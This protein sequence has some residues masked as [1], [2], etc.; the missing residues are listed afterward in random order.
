MAFVPGYDF[1]IFI[2]RSVAFSP[3]GKTIASGGYDKTVQLWKAESGEEIIVF[4]EHLDY[5]S[6]VAFSPDGKTVVSG[7]KDKTVR[8]V[9]R[10]AR[11]RNERI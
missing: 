5:V 7:S 2:S 9:E 1:D 10:S 6:S 3:D 8:L 11:Q 4:K